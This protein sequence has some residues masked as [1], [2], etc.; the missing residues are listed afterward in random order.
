MA[1]G[2]IFPCYP[3]HRILLFFSDPKPACIVWLNF[4]EEYPTVTLLMQA[5]FWRGA[6]LYLQ[7]WVVR[8]IIC[9]C[10]PLPEKRAADTNDPER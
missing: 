2:S 6:H 10:S 3:C 8:R 7:T 5:L 9:F 1:D 4:R